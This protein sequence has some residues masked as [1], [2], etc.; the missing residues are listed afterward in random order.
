ML[1]R[2][3]TLA[4]PHER[5]F[6]K[7]SYQQVRENC[8]ENVDNCVENVEKLY[9]GKLYDVITEQNL[10]Q[11]KYVPIA[12]VFCFHI[13]V[14]LITIFIWS[15]RYIYSGHQN[16][17]GYVEKSLDASSN[18]TWCGVIKAQYLHGIIQDFWPAITL[19]NVF[20]VSYTKE[21]K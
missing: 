9:D 21:T 12:V 11:I 13:N 10:T 4:T 15:Y 18:V 20:E 2:F 14:L 5:K 16:T 19:Y 8:V 3:H 6:W 17:K 7:N 1:Y